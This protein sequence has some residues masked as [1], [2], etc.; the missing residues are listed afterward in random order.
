MLLVVGCTRSH[1]IKVSVINNS[2]EKLSNIIIDYPSATFG[3]P[4][5]APGKTFLYAIK[6]TENGAIKI[7]FINAHGKT[8]NFP[9]PAV[10]KDDEGTMEINLTQDAAVADTKLQHR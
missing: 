10:N 2:P 8:N 5:L 4:S 9:G 3:V 6:V 1:V 7:E